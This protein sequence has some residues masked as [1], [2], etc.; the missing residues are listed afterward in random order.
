MAKL[1]RDEILRGLIQTL[2][3]GWG[4]SAVRNA[5]EELGS[6]QEFGRSKAPKGRADDLG[7][8]AAKLVSDLEISPDRKAVLVELAER[9][10]EGRAFPKLRDIKSF[11]L[12]HHRDGADLKTRETAFKRMLPVLIEMSPKGLE[13]LLARSHHSGPAD[14]GAISDAIRGTGENL[15]GGVSGA[16]EAGEGELPLARGRH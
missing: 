9:F 15:R 4:Q 6:S 13:K 16:K 1:N 12:S 11:L 14:L 7:P 10:D 8:K 5:L 2:V 3:D